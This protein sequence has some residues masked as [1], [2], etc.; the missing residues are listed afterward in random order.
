[1]EYLSQMNFIHRDLS[2]RNCLLSDDMRAVVSDFGLSKELIDKTYYKSYSSGDIPVRWMAIES[3]TQRK[4]STS[5]D[6]WSYGV[7]VWE[8]M[9]RGEYPYKDIDKWYLIPFFLQQN[10]RLTKPAEGDPDIYQ[11]CLD[12]WHLNPL[13]RPNFSDIVVKVSDMRSIIFTCIDS[14]SDYDYD[15]NSDDSGY[16][17]TFK[18]VAYRK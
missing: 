15:Y 10:K 18:T 17:L 14:D 2:A 1:M 12:C 5:S 9:T 11:L 7:L 13:L 8:L 4:Y 3:I 16:Y 6:V